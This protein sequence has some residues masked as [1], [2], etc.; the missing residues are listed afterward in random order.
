LPQGV[1]EVAPERNVQVLREEAE[2]AVP[3]EQ[4]EGREMAGPPVSAGGI[5]PEPQVEKVAQTETVPEAEAADFLAE[6]AEQPQAPIVPEAAE[7]EA[8]HIWQISHQTVR[9]QLPAIQL[10]E[11]AARQETAER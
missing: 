11:N 7:A 10:M 5:P 9:E 6:E 1:V 3:Q 4:T 8:D 2:A